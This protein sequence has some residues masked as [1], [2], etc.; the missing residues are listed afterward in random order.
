M[1]GSKSTL[2]GPKHYRT[3]NS[4]SK[5]AELKHILMHKWTTSVL[6][7]VHRFFLSARSGST[8]YH[9]ALPNK[10][11]SDHTSYYIDGFLHLVFAESLSLSQSKDSD[12]QIHTLPYCFAEKK[13]CPNTLVGSDASLLPCWGI[14]CLITLLRH[15]QH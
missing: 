2:T 9:N 15:T 13:P 6:R 3:L 7:L 10:I 8:R 4:S 12:A 1:C 11:S 5:F 14:H